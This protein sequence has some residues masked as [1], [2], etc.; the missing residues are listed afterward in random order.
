[1]ELSTAQRNAMREGVK[2]VLV[3]LQDSGQVDKIK[4]G[5]TSAFY[6]W[7]CSLQHGPL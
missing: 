4:E 2:R 7:R 6:A 3:Q 1:M 5:E